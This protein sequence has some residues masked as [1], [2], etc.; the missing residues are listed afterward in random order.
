MHDCLIIGAGQFGIACAEKLGRAG[1][2]ALLVDADERVGETWRRRPRRLQLF[3]PRSYSSIC[4]I[5]MSGDPDGY[6]SGLEYGNY[7]ASV[8]ER[9]GIDVAHSTRVE[10]L[11]RDGD[12]ASNGAFVARLADGRSVRAR[13]VI[14]AAGANQ[15]QKIPAFAARLDA[16]VKQIAAGAYRDPDDFGVDQTI[17]IVG[18][19]ASG[20][21][22]A[23]ELVEAGRRV[24]LARGRIRK[25]MPNRLLGR[26]LF[27]WLDLTGVAYADRDSAIGRILR[28]RDPIPVANCR[29]A[30]LAARGVRLMARATDADGRA[31]VFA[32]GGRAEVD[33]VLWCGG[34]RS[35]EHYIASTGRPE[36]PLSASASGSHPAI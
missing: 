28:K 24:V 1:V 32:D 13:T 22:I 20:R 26:S 35:R 7:L 19:G 9:L 30:I 34:H 11:E 8:V 5:A 17:C 10:R 16:N 31:V 2:D 15:A 21:Q 6:P 25:M 27:W 14:D 3:T 4:G 18:D 23:L 29:D 33:A 12:G 36:T